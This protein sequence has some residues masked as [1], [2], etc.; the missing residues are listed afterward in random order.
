MLLG[1][2]LSEL[3]DTDVVSFDMIKQL[4]VW[5][6][7]YDQIEAS[8]NLFAGLTDTLEQAILKYA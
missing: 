1:V 5:S 7:L 3:H 8:V 2:G 4:I 6:Q